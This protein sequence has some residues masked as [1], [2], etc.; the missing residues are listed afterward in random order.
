MVASHRLP[1]TQFSSSLLLREPLL[2][3]DSVFIDTFLCFCHSSLP[4]FLL[5]PAKCCQYFSVSTE[6]SSD[7]ALASEEYASSSV[8]YLKK[9]SL[10]GFYICLGFIA[11]VPSSAA[12]TVLEPMMILWS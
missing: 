4:F 2:Q 6:G 1:D 12:Q 8:Q 3:T 10:C 5:Y 9:M 7:Y 11:T